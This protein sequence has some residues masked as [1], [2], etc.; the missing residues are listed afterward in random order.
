MGDDVDDT[1]Q[2]R[3]DV[4][5]GVLVVCMSSSPGVSFCQSD[6]LEFPLSFFHFQL[7]TLQNG[8][9]EFSSVCQVKVIPSVGVE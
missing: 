4:F 2:Y 5:G 1:V 7:V 8:G 6:F 9:V 3:F